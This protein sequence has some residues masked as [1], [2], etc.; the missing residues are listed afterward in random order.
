MNCFYE[1][2]GCKVCR[3]A[4]EA[5]L[6]LNN[7]LPIGDKIQVIDLL[8][9]DPRTSVL[10]QMFGTNDLELIPIPVLI[11]ENP[12]INQSF[13]TFI[14]DKGSRVSIHSIFEFNHHLTFL[15]RLLDDRVM[16]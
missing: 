3:E 5:I 14:K 15:K 9:G 6:H 11:T 2:I 7:E 12:I 13:N 8:S 4:E 1:I 10:K 16:I